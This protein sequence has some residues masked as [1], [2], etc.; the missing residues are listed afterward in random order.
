MKIWATD[1]KGESYIQKQPY[2]SPSQESHKWCPS[3]GGPVTRRHVV[4]GGPYHVRGIVRSA[5]LR[6]RGQAELCQVR[7]SSVGLKYPDQ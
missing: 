4:E 2:I 3:C 6:I 7:D 5:G 1:I